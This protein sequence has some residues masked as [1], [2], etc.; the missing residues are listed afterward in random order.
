MIS[1]IEN[2]SHTVDGIYLAGRAMNWAAGE[3]HRWGELRVPSGLVGTAQRAVDPAGMT[4]RYCFTNPT[5]HPVTV[6]PGAAGV[7]TP[8]S[9]D[10]E[11]AD[12]CQAARCH[13]HIWCGGT[14]A[15]VDARAMNAQPPH[16]GL[17]LTS[18]SITSYAIERRETSNDRGDILLLTDGFTLA[19]GETYTLAWTLFSYESDF[20]AALRRFPN[21]VRFA[22]DSFTFFA[23]ESVRITADG[24]PLETNPALGYHETAVRGAICR[25]QVLPPWETLL[26][27]RCE[28]IARYQQIPDGAFAGA[29]VIYDN[30]TGA[31]IH[32]E[33]CRDH[34]SGRERIGMGLLMAKYLQ[35]HPDPALRA[36]LDAYTDFLLRAYFDEPTG[37]VFNAY[38]RDNS[39]RRIYNNAWFASYFRELYRL[40]DNVRWLR[41]MM[42]ALRDLYAHGG[43]RFYPLALEATDAVHALDEAGL[44]AERAE[45]MTL[46]RQNAA[47][48]RENGTHY[49]ALEVNYEDNIVVPAGMLLVQLYELTGETS[50]LT[51]AQDHLRLHDIFVGYQPDARMH[52]AAIH[53]WDD[54][55]FGKYGLFGDTFPHYWTTTGALFSARMAA[56]TGS[57]VDLAHARAGMRASLCSFF[58]DGRA[59]CA[60][61]TPRTVNDRPGAFVDPWANDQD[62]ALYHAM[63]F[64]AQFGL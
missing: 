8:F 9:D 28:F 26:R 58:P 17:A 64:D 2:A 30:D 38:P 48:I 31:R 1:Y 61:V 25:Y 32:D 34:N 21:Q 45:L 33:T 55:Y 49:P 50:Y 14:S 39:H 13:A 5:D 56:A 12:V 43:L 23:D 6:Q 18:G 20:F 41:C 54:H 51:A 57:A 60:I 47:F 11:S 52:G 29:Y 63:Q 62:W 7:W 19:P 4:E 36:S 27:T 46:L 3:F 10:Y 59:T 35:T 42:G 40:T 44:T 37:E 53:H 16:L 24:V 22:A 15:W